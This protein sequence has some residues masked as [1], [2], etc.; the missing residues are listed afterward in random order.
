MLPWAMSRALF[1][2][3]ARADPAAARRSA[4]AAVATLG[5]LMTPI[6]LV[7][8]I[9]LWPFLYVWIGSTL[10]AQVADISYLFVP[11]LWM[12]AL[13]VVPYTLVVAQQRPRIAALIHVGQVIPYAV[14]LYL[15]MRGGGLTGVAVLWTLRTAADALLFLRFSGSGGG[16]FRSAWPG[17]ALVCAA[18]ALA[19]ALPPDS[20]ARWTGQGLLLVLGVVHAVRLAPP[21]IRDRIAGLLARLRGRSAAE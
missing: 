2:S 18:T 12:N 9:M 10:A 8:I 21:A 11:G 17:L 19:V 14:L 20:Y 16:G 3:L 15:A 13:A 6:C 1:P 4:D 7:A 5:A